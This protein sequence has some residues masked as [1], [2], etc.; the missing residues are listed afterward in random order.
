MSDWFRVNSG[1]PRH[2]KVRRLSDAAF[3]LHV[4]A[5]ARVADDETDGFLGPED[6]A[7]AAEEARQ[8]ERK[9]PALVDELVTRGLWDELLGGSS[10]AIHDWLDL[11]P[12]HA[13]L[14]RARDLQR[15]RTQR[16]RA[17]A[18]AAR[19]DQDLD[20]NETADE[21]GSGP[22]GDGG[23]D[24]SRHGGVTKPRNGTVRNGTVRSTTRGSSSSSTSPEHGSRGDDDGA[25]TLGF[26]GGSWPSD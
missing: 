3:R 9:V 16:W 11:N 1:F 17:K 12:S 20:G 4:C 15:Q 22:A 25:A 26:G 5:M 6:L 19:G 14:E 8:P 7:D 21:A 23:G 13:D 2:R 18:A 24:A 10:W